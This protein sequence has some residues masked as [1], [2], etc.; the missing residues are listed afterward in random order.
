MANR[1]ITQMPP[2]EGTAINENDLLTLVHIFEVDPTLKNKKITFTEFRNYLDQYYG[3]ASLSGDITLSGS[4][5]ITGSLTVSGTTSTF[6]SGHFTS[7]VQVDGD[8]RVN[9]DI[10][11]GNTITGNNVNANI[12]NISTIITNNITGVTYSGIDATFVTGNIQEVYATYVTGAVVEGGDARFNTITGATQISGQTIIGVTGEFTQLNVDE[13]DVTGLIEID[14]LVATGF[15]SGTLITGDNISGTSGVFQYISG[16]EITGDTVNVTEITGV[17]G[18]FTQQISGAT[19]TGDFLN[20]GTGN[21]AELNAANLQFS[22]DQTISGNFDIEGSGIVASG[23]SVTGDSYFADEVFFNQDIHVSGSG[24]F[25]S[26][27]AA[28]PTIIFKDDPDT[29]FYHDSTPNQLGFA[30]SG[31]PRIIINDTGNVGFHVAAPLENIH[32]SGNIRTNQTFLGSG[33]NVSGTADVSGLI[34]SGEAY[35]QSGVTVSGDLDV[36]GTVTAS[37][38][39]QISGNVQVSGLTV[40]G[41]AFFQSGVTISGELETSGLDVLNDATISGDLDVSGLITTSGLLVTGETSG[42]VFT[43]TAADTTTG[44]QMGSGIIAGSGDGP[45]ASVASGNAVIVR[46]PLIILP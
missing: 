44:L 4:L 30:T 2:I 38:E 8:L 22:G 11:A 28:A 18:V 27:T 23:I 43:V 31:E 6:V 25:E 41:E 26:G 19:I 33:L 45:I 24:I 10:Y 42:N 12:G 40:T 29:G 32:A 14:D 16:A 1:K 36:S 17:S 39:I 20:V 3:L 7:G 9:Q 37:G 35:F 5:T 46:G 13:L 21:F 15:I 34:V